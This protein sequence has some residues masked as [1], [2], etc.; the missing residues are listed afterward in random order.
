ML[1]SFR[2]LGLVSATLAILPSAMAKQEVE[3]YVYTGSLSLDIAKVPFSSRGSYL[4]FSEFTE[5]NLARFAGTGLPPGVYLRSVH[6]DQHP[7]FRVE[8]LDAD[9]P[10]PFHVEASPYLLRLQAAMGS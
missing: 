7:V 2:L 9:I 10:V 5:D 4:V 8:L 1:F 3:P 6:G